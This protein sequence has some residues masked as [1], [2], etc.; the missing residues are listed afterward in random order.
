M[1]MF[2]QS[3]GINKEVSTESIVTSATLEMGVENKTKN[4][5]KKVGKVCCFQEK[6]KKEEGKGAE[7]EWATE[8][9]TYFYEVQGCWIGNAHNDLLV[10]DLETRQISC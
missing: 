10:L 5:L 7:E 1:T 8:K 6:G 4:S 2:T 3:S 9:R